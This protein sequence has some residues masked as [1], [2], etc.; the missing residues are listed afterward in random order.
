M[1]KNKFKIGD[2]IS[3]ECGDKG[4]VL[5]IGQRPDVCDIKKMGVYAHWVKEGLAFWMD[6]DEPQI[7]LY[8]EEGEKI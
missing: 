7:S 8:A 3:S 6:I 2:M 4:L 1:K 5:Q